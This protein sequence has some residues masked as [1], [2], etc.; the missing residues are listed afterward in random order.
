MRILFIHNSLQ[1]FVRVDRDIL[2]S[3]HEVDELDLSRRT[4]IMSL[5]AR[6]RQ[7]DLVFAWFAGLHSLLPILAATVARK[8]SI[9]VVGGYDTANLAEIGYGHMEH[10]WKRYVVRLICRL[11]TILVANSNAAAEEVRGNVRTHTPVRVIYHGFAL[12][13][14]P[15]CPEREYLA[16][17]VGGVSQE[18]M[19]RKGHDVFVR[20]ATLVPEYRFLLVGRWLDEAVEGL[21]ESAPSNVELTGFL[22]SGELEDLMKRA[23]VY[24]QASAHEGFGCSVAEAMLAGCIPVV[25]RRGA[26]PEV[27]GEQ[28]IFVDH[29]DPISVARGVREASTASPAARQ[30]A[31]DHIA[32]NFPLHLRRERLLGLV[33][34]VLDSPPRG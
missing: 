14:G 7:A 33:Q 2:A 1:S 32:A 24:V 8:S 10:P 27:V 13:D 22:S 6:M 29:D 26:L 11:A 30:A 3:A 12:P 15:I 9:V 34:S 31:S 25:S 21:C 17:T 18:S 4:R 20:A 28:G 23:S 16:L 19:Q 5:P